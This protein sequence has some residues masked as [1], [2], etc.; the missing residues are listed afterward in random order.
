MPFTLLVV[1]P[2]NQR[3]LALHAAGQIANAGALLARWN[4]LHAV[5][6]GLS[7]VAFVVLLVAGR[8]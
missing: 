3:L 8:R 2:T 4:A 6:T 1:F 5:R 7:L